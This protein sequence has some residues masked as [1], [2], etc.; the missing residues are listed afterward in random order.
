MDPNRAFASRRFLRAAALALAPLLLGGCATIFTGTSDQIAF[1]SN[2]P[3]V[4]LSIDGE[5]KGELPLTVEV[6]R[7]APE[8][9]RFLARFERTGYVTQEFELKREF[10][11]VSLLDVPVF[12]V[13]FP[14]DMVSGAIMRFEPE[15]YH[16]QMLPDPGARA[17]P[18]ESPVCRVERR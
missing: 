12:I 5:Y 16:V 14:V 10:N 18:A 15:S 11:L 6:N 1:A 9:G 17:A 8:G 13:G 4:R 3:R 2:V 7:K